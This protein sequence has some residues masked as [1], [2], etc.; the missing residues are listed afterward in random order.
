MF[1]KHFIETNQYSSQTAAL[2][3]FI[4]NKMIVEFSDTGALY[5]YNQNHNQVKLITSRQRSLNSTNDLKIPSMQLLIEISEWGSLY[6][7]EE[8]R[9][10]HQG[11]WQ[12]RL[13]SWIQKMVL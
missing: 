1:L 9:M 8:G 2:V 5:V 12:S 7:N 6:F 10:T 4:K 11:H 3:L 13:S